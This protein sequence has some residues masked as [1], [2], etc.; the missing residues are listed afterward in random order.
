MELSG[1]LGAVTKFVREISD[2]FNAFV[3][4]QSN[5]KVTET[6]KVLPVYSRLWTLLSVSENYSKNLVYIVL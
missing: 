4:E 2:I 6:T 3:F 5:P 1:Q